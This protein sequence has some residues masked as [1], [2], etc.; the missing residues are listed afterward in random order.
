[1]ITLIKDLNVNFYVFADTKKRCDRSFG[2]YISLGFT[3]RRK[4]TR[5]LLFGTILILVF[6]FKSRLEKNTVSGLTLLNTAHHKDPVYF[7]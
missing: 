1:M 5:T 2:Q 7:S 3:L 4:I 6:V